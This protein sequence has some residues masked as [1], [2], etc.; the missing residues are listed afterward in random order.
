M[1]RRILLCLAVML[2]GMVMAGCQTEE[3]KNTGEA[4]TQEASPVPYSRGPTSPPY[5]KGPSGPPPETAN[6]ASVSNGETQAVTET[7][8]VRY[9]LPENPEVKVK[10]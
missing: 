2:S 4:A 3:V 7:E 9:S 6:P 5:V 1:N 10:Q 8:T